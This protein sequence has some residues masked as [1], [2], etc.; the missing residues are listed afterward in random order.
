VEARQRSRL[1]RFAVAALV[2]IVAATA[3]WHL[4]GPRAG[5]GVGVV[6]YL[7]TAWRSDGNLG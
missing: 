2:S 7:V 5:L 1:R 3:V 4:V 6:G